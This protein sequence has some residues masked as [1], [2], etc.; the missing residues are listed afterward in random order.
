MF[1]IAAMLGYAQ[2]FG[3]QPVFCEDPSVSKDHPESLLNVRAFFPEIPL[4]PDVQKEE[5]VVLH[6]PANGSM[7]YLELPNIPKNVLL[8]GYFQSER[9]FPK[10]GIPTC[11]PFFPSLT[12]ELS[13]QDWSNLFFLHV[14][15]GDYLHP[16]NQH[17]VI[18]VRSYYQKSLQHFSENQ[19]CFVVSDDIHWCKATLPT[20][21]QRRWL[22][23]PEGLS[24]AET[25]F[26]MTLCRGGICGNSSFSWWAAY[27]QKS[28]ATNTCICMP[29]PW[30]GPAFPEARDLIPEWAIRVQWS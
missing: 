8:K 2:R 20:W 29:Y 12:N 19:I 23:C 17:H 30:G 1:K 13:Q 24:D 5:W 18:D 11:L 3:H 15:R 27:F 10:I 7:T 25:F 21:F 4:L 16:L 6:E 14:R 28:R 26:W 22:F 9:Y